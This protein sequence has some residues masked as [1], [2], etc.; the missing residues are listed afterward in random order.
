M[1]QI[2]KLASTS[3]ETRIHGWYC[4]ISISFIDRQLT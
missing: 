3:H 2:K 1:T 4:A